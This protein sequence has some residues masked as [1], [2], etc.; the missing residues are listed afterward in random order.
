MGIVVVRS[1]VVFND[2][3]RWRIWLI[4]GTNV[5][6]STAGDIAVWS[7][8]DLGSAF[9]RI[10]NNATAVDNDRIWINNTTTDFN[11]IWSYNDSFDGFWKF[12]FWN[13]SE[14]FIWGVFV[15]RRGASDACVWAAD[16]D[17]ARAVW[18]TATGG[19]WRRF[20]WR[21]ECINW[22]AIRG[23]STSNWIKQ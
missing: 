17:D 8:D 13:S 18:R 7:V 1:S 16:D 2:V 3:I 5:I 4:F 6:W 9:I 21:A 19:H 22:R 12:E 23:E 11:W 10:W 20:I 14:F 15:W